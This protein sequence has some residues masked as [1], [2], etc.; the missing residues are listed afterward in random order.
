MSRIKAA[1]RPLELTFHLPIDGQAETFSPRNSVDLA[2]V[3]RVRA[4]T[5]G[6][7]D[8]DDP[9]D[10]GAAGSDDDEYVDAATELQSFHSLQGS[11]ELLVSNLICTQS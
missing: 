5:A 8:Y 4:S 6:P 7:T 11:A 3:R 10:K 1:G 9:K 2:P